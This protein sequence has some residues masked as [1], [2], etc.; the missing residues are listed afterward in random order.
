M[1]NF[2]IMEALDS[3]K[4]YR[5]KNADSITPKQ[6][7]WFCVEICSALKYLWENKIVHRDL[8]LDNILFSYACYPVLCDF[9]CADTTD[10]SGC[11]ERP[12]IV[13]GNNRHLAPEVLNSWRNKTPIINYSKQPSW[14]LGI[15]CFEI[16]TLSHPFDSYP[17]LQG[18]VSVTKLDTTWL[19]Q[20]NYPKPFIKL[21]ES[22]VENDF[23]KRMELSEAFDKLQSLHKE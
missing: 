18:T 2:I 12:S 14:E 1:A 7:I 13:G 8:K 21:V 9:G 16:A 4:D 15:I 3:F 17:P 20:L 11:I 19:E 23:T 5:A 6:C 10:E 22:L